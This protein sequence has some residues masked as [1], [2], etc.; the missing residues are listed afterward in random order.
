VSDTRAQS[1]SDTQNNMAA[2][3][4]IT[5]ATNHTARRIRAGG[6]GSL[7]ALTTMAPAAAP[8]CHR[9]RRCQADLLLPPAASTSA[10]RLVLLPKRRPPGVTPARQR[11]RD[12]RAE[13]QG[14]GVDLRPSKPGFGQ[15]FA[16]AA[17][18]ARGPRALGRLLGR[19]AHVEAAPSS[20]LAAAMAVA[21]GL[22]SGRV[23]EEVLEA[24][25]Q[26]QRQQRQQQRQ[27]ARDPAVVLL[28]G[29]GGAG[30]GGG[31][32][33]GRE[34]RRP[35]APPAPP[36]PLFPLDSDLYPTRL[37]HCRAIATVCAAELR[38]RLQAE[39]DE[40]RQR[41]RR[42]G[43]GAGL[44]PLDQARAAYSLAR[45]GL[46]DPDLLD[47]LL[48]LSGSDG[49]EGEDGDGCE[50][51][52]KEGQGTFRAASPLSPTTAPCTPFGPP[53]ALAG[54]AA[55]LAAFSHPVPP[56]WL[57][58]WRVESFRDLG[59]MDAQQLATAAFAMV[60]LT[61]QQRQQQ[62]QEQ[63]Q[64]QDGG[65][66]GGGGRGG[67]GGGDDDGGENNNDSGT[68]A[69]LEVASRA[70]RA[71]WM[72][73]RLSSGARAR[74]S[75]RACHPQS[76]V[77]FAVALAAAT[78]GGWE[79]REEGRAAAEDAAAAADDDGA[80]PWVSPLAA[81]PPLPTAATAALRPHRGP[82]APPPRF[83]PSF[84]WLAGLCAEARRG[85]DA[86]APRE[87][88]ALLWALARL[89]AA[90]A[91]AAAVP[92]RRRG[93]PPRFTP[94]AAFLSS[95]CRAAAGRMPA[96]DSRSLSVAVE[97]LAV[98]IGERGGGG[99]GRPRLDPATAAL[100]PPP[101]PQFEIPAR[102]AAAVLARSAQLL[103]NMRAERLAALLRALAALRVRPGAAWALRWLDAFG[104][105]FCALSSSSSPAAAAGPASPP[106]PLPPLPAPALADVA[107]SLARLRL[108]PGRVWLRVLY[109]AADAA[110]PGA[111]AADL[112][113]LCWAAGTLPPEAA[114]VESAGEEGEVDGGSNINNNGSPGRRGRPRRAWLAALGA[115]ARDARH[116]ANADAAAASAA[117]AAGAPPA[118]LEQ[119]QR[120]RAV[121]EALAAFVADEVMTRPPRRR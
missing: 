120:Q 114:A 15:R 90:A 19:R 2:T 30:V 11:R 100:P 49:L 66:G 77:R 115:R 42:Q 110:V 32:G 87:L 39:R 101:P 70:M 57:E 117:A 109:D 111:S 106:P 9:R 61:E 69:W 26:Q 103:P 97:A 47:L 8:R 6:Y 108:D 85:V 83:R 36:P 98:L 54:M 18:A 28:S 96:F 81:L 31:G 5:T 72:E 102:L 95:W 25:G 52:E 64:E 105:R 21:A 38:L 93:A 65:G 121:V 71:R 116:L 10:S 17:R 86:L 51:G 33:G 43:G 1:Y 45:L 56:G 14:D 48:M 7:G 58:R 55:A 84:N 82:S 75:G 24:A 53:E 59:A 13:Q 46:Y 41:P 91:A 78:G 76:L 3:T 62:R 89:G 118:S 88:A 20:A 79:G 50:D 113:A 44:R 27:Q 112:A 22:A 63:Q 73:G 40:R 107:W 74:G 34:S 67:R 119:Q 60:R 23:S 12:K 29:G 99:S 35:L 80:L 37:A 16:Q 4:S 104:A 94:D 92:G 68:A